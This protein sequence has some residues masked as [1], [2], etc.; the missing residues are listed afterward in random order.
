MV[1]SVIQILRDNIKYVTKPAIRRLARR[2]GVKRI[3]AGVYDEVRGVLHSFL[4]TVISDSICY[5]E[6]A[7][8]KTVTSLDVIYALK[9]RGRTLSEDISRNMLRTSSSLTPYIV[10]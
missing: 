1:L 5:T 10:L 2:G 7:N 3:S 9:R 8:R 4:R 6:H